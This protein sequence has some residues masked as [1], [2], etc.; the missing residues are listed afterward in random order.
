M[1]PTIRKADSGRSACLP[2]MIS[3]KPRMVSFSG[4]YLPSMPVNC[5]ATEKGWDR[6]RWIFRARETVS[7]SSSLSSSMPMMAMMSCSSR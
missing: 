6:K 2:S 7:L 3:L 4:T 1:G 5:S